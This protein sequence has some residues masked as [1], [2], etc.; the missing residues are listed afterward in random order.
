MRFPAFLLAVVGSLAAVSAQTLPAAAWPAFANET[1]FRQSAL[2]WTNAYRARHRAPYIKW[3]TTLAAYAQRWTDQC[4]FAHSDPTPSG[5]YGENLATNT[6]NPTAA[7]MA[8]AQEAALYNYNTGV[9]SAQTG[10]FT[11][12]VWKNTQYLGCSRTYCGGDR[13]DGTGRAYGWFM[14]CEYW[15]RGNIRGRFLTNVFPP[16]AS[17]RTQR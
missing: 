12:L 9:F 13:P 8:W 5:L 10:H 6:Q 7:V 3:N 11:Q 1:Q 14:A 15:P 2:A 17:P 4:M 16:V